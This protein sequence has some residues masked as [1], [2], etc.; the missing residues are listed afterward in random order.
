MLT[1]SLSSVDLTWYVCPL[2]P[3]CPWQRFLVQGRTRHRTSTCEGFL[4]DQKVGLTAKRPQVRSHN[5]RTPW[6]RLRAMSQITNHVLKMSWA[7]RL[8]RCNGLGLCLHICGPTWTATA[9]RPGDL[10]S[11]QLLSLPTGT[12]IIHKL[13]DP[14]P[15]GK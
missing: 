9:F 7:L 11:F 1:S 5:K 13:V 14:S 6:R 2:S 8:P 10:L 15:A 4:G 12:V 3:C